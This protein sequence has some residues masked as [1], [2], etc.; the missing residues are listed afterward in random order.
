MPKHRTQLVFRDKQEHLAMVKTPNIS[1]PNQY[2]DTEIPHISRAHVVLP[3]T[4][5]YRFYIHIYSPVY[6]NLHQVDLSS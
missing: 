5:K 1:R 2:F 6:S 4:I 3:Q